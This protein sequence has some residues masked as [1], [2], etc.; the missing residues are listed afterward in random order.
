M[1][2]SKYKDVITNVTLDD[3]FNSFKDKIETRTIQWYLNSHNLSDDDK[4]V[5][6]IESHDYTGIFIDIREYNKDVDNIL[7]YGIITEGNTS[8]IDAF[9]NRTDTRCKSESEPDIVMVW[10]RKITDI[11]RSRMANNG[12]IFTE[13]WYKV[14]FF[15]NETE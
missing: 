6:P 15:T 2:N 12:L 5:K 8:L 9:N 3:F 1:I 4:R 7:P 13:N 10:V 11:E 14:G